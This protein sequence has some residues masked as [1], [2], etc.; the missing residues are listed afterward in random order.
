[1]YKIG[2]VDEAPLEVKRITR[3]LEEDFEMVNYDIPKGLPKQELIDQIYKSDIDLLMVDY[4]LTDRGMLLYNGDS[5]V[6]DFEKVKP[7]FPMII[8][9][10]NEGDAFPQVDNP[11]IIYNKNILD[12]DRARFVNVLKKNIAYYEG[13]VEDRKRR[14]AEL[15]EIKKNQELS[16]LE[17]NELFNLQLDLNKLD[18]RENKE[19]PN[20]LLSEQNLDHLSDITEDAERLLQQ[21]TKKNNGAA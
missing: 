16:S 21:L 20:H 1:M 14:V 2:Y 10:N 6:R 11:N 5:V 18:E 8:F 19:T 15:F 4:L 7:R 3:K 13:Y 12:E 9:T 17:K